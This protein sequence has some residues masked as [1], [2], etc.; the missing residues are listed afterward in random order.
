[1]PWAQDAGRSYANCF[2]KA[3]C[4]VQSEARTVFSDPVNEVPFSSQPDLRVLFFTS[5]VACGVGILFS[6]APA[7]RFLRPDLVTS[8]KQQTGTAGGSPLR[9]RRISVGAQIAV[10]LLLLIGAG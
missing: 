3:C 1:M 9:F 10:S 6:L 4:W 8:L 7:L 2:W 5:I